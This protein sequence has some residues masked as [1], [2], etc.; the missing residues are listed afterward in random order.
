MT[1]VVHERLAGAVTNGGIAR[2]RV[3]DRGGGEA[4][5]IHVSFVTIIT[6][7][8]RLPW[9]GAEGRD[10]HRRLHGHW[11]REARAKHSRTKSPNTINHP[12]DDDR[13]NE[14]PD[15]YFGPSAASGQGANKVASDPAE[16]CADYSRD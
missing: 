3:T 1:R 5:I 14:R 12:T 6:S 13:A 15:K 2:F 9:P 16:H 4:T 7:H 8:A 10:A 11:R